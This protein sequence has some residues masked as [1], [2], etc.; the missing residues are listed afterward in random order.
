MLSKYEKQYYRSRVVATEGAVPKVLFLDFGNIDDLLGA[1]FTVDTFLHLFVS[2]LLVK[3]AVERY[4]E[5]PEGLLNF[6]PLALKTTLLDS[7]VKF[8]TLHEGDAITLTYLQV[9]QDGIFTALLNKY[10]EKSKSM[11]CINIEEPIPSPSTSTTI[12][13]TSPEPLRKASRFF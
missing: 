2:F 10:P 8:E 11:S 3:H 5:L 7:P 6:A 13:T 1:L 4:Y 12:L 9:S